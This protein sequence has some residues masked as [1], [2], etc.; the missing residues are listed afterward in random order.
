LTRYQGT[1]KNVAAL[2]QRRNRRS[3]VQYFEVILEL[4][5]T[6]PRL[7]KPGQ[8]VRADLLLAD[9]DDVISVPRQAVIEEEDGDKLVYRRSGGDFEPVKVELGPSAL[10]RVVI[11]SGLE[12]GDV[13][14]LADPTRRS[15]ETDSPAAS[16]KVRGGPGAGS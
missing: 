15:T 2:A 6:E 3:P 1:V 9:L 13:I 8:R 5:R 12:E 14:A 10:G 11:E 4:E 16:S 7:M